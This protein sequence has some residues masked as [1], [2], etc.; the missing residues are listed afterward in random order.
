MFRNSMVFL[1]FFGLFISC[2][3]N[4]DSSDLSM[5]N[6]DKLLLQKCKTHCDTNENCLEDCK[7][8]FLIMEKEND[9]M[10][11][12]G[13][14]LFSGPEADA[15]RMCSCMESALDKSGDGYKKAMEKCEKLGK[16]FEDK[17]GHNEQAMEKGKKAAEECMKPL[18]EKL[19]KKMMEAMRSGK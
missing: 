2:N 6:L 12:L 17:Y 10:T 16:K 18:E 14:E 1:A 5:H 19:M 13:R 3:S 15:K 4:N 9:V 7:D 8:R 11:L